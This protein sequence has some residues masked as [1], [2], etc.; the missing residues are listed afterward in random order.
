MRSPAS[1]HIRRRAVL[2]QRDAT[3]VG[4]EARLDA[5][6]ALIRE[7]AASLAHSQKIFDR[8]SAAARI[9]VWQCNLADQALHWTDMV[10][11]LFDLPRGS[12]LVRE[13]IVKCYTAA[14]AVEL[15]AKRSKGIAERTGFGLDAEI[16]TAKGNHRWIR[17]TASVECEDG[18]AVRI[19]GMKQD[20]TEEKILADQTRYL[21]EYDV[22]TGLANRSR[23]QSKLSEVT[24]DGD[25]RP[26][27]GALLLV[28]LDGFKQINDTFGH[29]AGDECLK[30][31]A[32]R[33]ES[34]CASVDLV[35]RIGGDEFAVL[36]GPG[37]DLAAVAE[38]AREI[39]DKVGRAVDHGGRALKLGA[40][41]GIALHEEC[42][43]SDLLV[44]A[45]TALY[46]AKSAG[47]NT[48]R[49]FKAAETAGVRNPRAA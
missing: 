35:S 11:D 20:I 19:F 33:L 49:I 22:L 29:V 26:S 48:F 42:T 37:L 6:A 18:V 13:E 40:S 17:I 41:I 45:D 30:E 38:L 2:R 39:I 15:H 23:F 3:I 1:R 14:S 32:R 27:L 34:A 8:S 7:Q 25:D 43:P 21:A 36:V 24:P 5:Q 9:G 4:L 31:V 47:R 16:V 46:A 28:D 12:P 44:R 10:Y